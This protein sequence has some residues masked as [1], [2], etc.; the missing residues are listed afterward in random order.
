MR[1][2]SRGR[3]H[4]CRST[5]ALAVL[6]GLGGCN[7]SKTP[8]FLGTDITG[9]DWGRDFHLFD[10]G[11]TPRSLADYRGK[12]VMLFF[13]FTHCPDMCPTALAK[14][15]QAH[16]QLGKDGERVQ[17]LFATLDP[18]RD[19]PAVLSRYVPAFDPSFVALTADTETID[20]TASSFKL[21]FAR[22][23]PDEN[24]NYSVDHSS[25]IFVFDPAGRLKLYERGD[26]PVD[27][28]VHDLKVLLDAS[29]DLMTTTKR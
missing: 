26:A 3:R 25:A 22:L 7:R 20:A 19:T 6:A 1:A 23:K 13:G 21:F 15:A 29:A 2:N 8:T 5:V 14:M 4:W 9:V 18:A 17:G 10:V 16:R 28:L 27:T 12:V 24:G 11:G